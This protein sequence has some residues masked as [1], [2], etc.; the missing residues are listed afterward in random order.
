[1]REYLISH[2]G[3]EW[4]ES[5]SSIHAYFSLTCRDIMDRLNDPDLIKKFKKTDHGATFLA[6]RDPKRVDRYE[7]SRL[8]VAAGLQQSNSHRAKRLRAAAE[9]ETTEIEK[10]TLDLS[11]SPAA[12][13]AAK[14]SEIPDGDTTT[15]KPAAVRLRPDSEDGSTRA[16]DSIETRLARVIE[17]IR[18]PCARGSAPD[19]TTTQDD[20]TVSSSIVPSCAGVG[21]SDAVVRP[22][23][24]QP[25]RVQR[26][27]Q[28]K[29]EDW[30]VWPMPDEEALLAFAQAMTPFVQFLHPGIV[31]AVVEDNRRKRGDWS[32]R[33]EALGIDPAIYLWEGSPC[34]FPGV[35][36]HAGSVELSMLQEQA[37]HAVPQSFLLDDNDYPKHLWAFVFTGESFCGR[38]PDGYRLLHLFNPE[39]HGN[40]CREVLDRPSGAKEWNPPYGLFTS[41]AA[42]MYVPGTF[43]RPTDF[44]PKLRN[45]IQRQALRLYGKICRILP[46][47]LE[48][49]PCEDPRW[50]IDHFQWSTPAG[51]MDN[52]PDFLE[53]RHE[54]IE[55]LFRQAVRR[56]DRYG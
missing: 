8:L 26:T 9:A 50:F 42:S 19:V 55:E 36:R 12:T 54:R 35:R 25:S 5:R 32:S 31:Y 49:K 41:A 20:S 37:A 18:G 4:V 46:P 21:V 29:A 23:V 39:E 30:P 1:M 15:P 27:G 22:Q 53:F 16:V 17:S 24:A 47:P 28:P 2:L 3:E 6:R 43:Q 10:G 14:G 52:V 38:E 45:L 34:A 51:A 11:L 44:S 48:V 13:A 33:L 56:T 7:K 40:H